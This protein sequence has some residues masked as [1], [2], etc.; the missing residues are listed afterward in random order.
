MRSVPAAPTNCSADRTNI[1]SVEHLGPFRRRRGLTN[2]AEL[3]RLEH[4]LRVYL[5]L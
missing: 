5:G 1:A 3:E 4:R 2:R